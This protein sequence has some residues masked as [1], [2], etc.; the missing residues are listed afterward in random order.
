MRLL[1]EFQTPYIFFTIKFHKHKKAQNVIETIQSPNR[2][3]Q[4]RKRLLRYTCT[5]APKTILIFNWVLIN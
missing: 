2:C 3:H 1:G 5:R 4:I